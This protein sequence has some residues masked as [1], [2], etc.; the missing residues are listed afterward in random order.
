MH[1]LSFTCIQISWVDFFQSML[2][3]ICEICSCV[4]FSCNCPSSKIAWAWECQHDRTYFLINMST[5]W[6]KYDEVSINIMNL[7]TP[8]VNYWNGTKFKCVAIT[9]HFCT[10]LLFSQSIYLRHE[11]EWTLLTIMHDY[12]F[13]TGTTD[14]LQV[15]S[16]PW[17]QDIKRLSL[18]LSMSDEV[19]TFPLLKAS[20]AAGKECFIPHY[21]GPHM[22]MVKLS[23]LE[24]YESLPVTKWN[25]KQPADDHELPDALETGRLWYC[26]Q[27]V[28]SLK[29]T[30]TICTDTDTMHAGR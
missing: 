17:F 1:C 21:K 8:L 6:D 5:Y 25:I 16:S 30:T 12:C 13:Y 27:A 24:E 18:F 19:E 26:G 4:P 22:S 28:T 7:I 20:L 3:I 23:S 15:L 2:T 29:T 9:D 10:S 11:Q 14:T